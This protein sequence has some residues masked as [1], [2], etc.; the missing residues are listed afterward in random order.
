MQPTAAGVKEKDPRKIYINPN[1]WTNRLTHLMLR[2]GAGSR[3]FRGVEAVLQD[4]E[5][6]SLLNATEVPFSVPEEL[7][8]VCRNILS[9]FGHFCAMWINCALTPHMDI[10]VDTKRVERPGRHI[11]TMRHEGILL[12]MEPILTFHSLLD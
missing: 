2:V 12:R 10:T 9:T 3:S 4:S 6:P 11:E 8:G 7:R 1:L 5:K